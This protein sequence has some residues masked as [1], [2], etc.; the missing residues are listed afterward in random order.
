[1]RRAPVAT[2]AASLVPD[3]GSFWLSVG[4]RCEVLMARSLMRN[5][6]YEFVLTFVLL[7]VVATILRFVIG[8]SPISD[9]LGQIR[10]ELLIVAL[11]V[12]FVVAALI[13]TPFGRAS[14]GHMNPA[15]SFA[16]WRFGVFPLVGVMPYTIAQLLG[17][18]LGVLAARLVWGHVL[19]DAPIA[20]AV[21][22]PAAGWSDAL[23]FAVEAT[24]FG[25]IVLVIGFCL[26]LPRVLPWMPLIVGLLAASCV[27]LLGLS[28]GGSD[29]PARQ[30]GPALAS[31]QFN[32]FWVYFFAPF[33]GALIAPWLRNVIQ[34]ERQVL[35]HRLCGTTSANPKT[36]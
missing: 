32:H 15:I 30:F 19:A 4:R 3:G 7:F 22:Q 34:R 33:V 12:C 13:L 29:N 20:Y 8:P 17:S 18:L 11:L 27:A 1:M 36:P 24:S 21:I 6:F 16:M 9:Q 31:G 5:S 35:T 26:A 23:L 10:A 2:C 25:V 14:G 28:S